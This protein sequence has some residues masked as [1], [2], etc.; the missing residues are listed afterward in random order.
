MQLSAV[1]PLVWSHR[2]STKCVH[3]FFL[4]FFLNNKQQ[5]HQSVQLRHSSADTAEPPTPAPQTEG[6]E[7]CIVIP[8]PTL[9]LWW[10]GRRQQNSS[11]G[12]NSKKRIKKKKRGKLSAN[13]IS[14]SNTRRD[15]NLGRRKKSKIRRATARL[16]RLRGAGLNKSMADEE[17]TKTIE[18][19]ASTKRPG[20][21]PCVVDA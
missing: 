1:S 17:E 21:C 20:G 8:P 14:L 12:V 13:T 9:L 10:E 4:I 15:T 19:L 6:R 3:S 5:L 7:M 18:L 11:G 2:E 16:V